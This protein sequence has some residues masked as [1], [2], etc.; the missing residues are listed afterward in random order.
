MTVAKGE[1]VERVV[2]Y[3]VRSIVEEPD[4]VSVTMVEQ[5]PDEVIAEV[6]TAKADMGRVIGR[7][8]RV[9]KA[10]RAAAGAAA[11]EEGITADVEFVD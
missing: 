6:R 9:A 11:D 1:I 4:E 5:G 7:R 8:G 10:I 2:T 3:V